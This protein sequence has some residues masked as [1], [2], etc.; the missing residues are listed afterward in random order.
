MS[1]FGLILEF[2]AFVRLR[3]KYPTVSRPY[4]IP[5]GTVGAIV[6]CIPP[7]ILICVVLTLSSLKNAV[8]S[9]VALVI[10]LVMQSYLKHVENKRWLKFST[11]ADLPD[12]H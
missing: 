8:V 12:L 10:G 2:I 1:C 4:K 6:M 9:I 5:I 11:N 7:T 3:M